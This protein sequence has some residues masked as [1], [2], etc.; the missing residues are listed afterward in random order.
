[1]QRVIN[2]HTRSPHRAQTNQISKTSK[3][4]LP[5][6]GLQVDKFQKE[7]GLVI[8]TGSD[9]WQRAK[10][11]SWIPGMPKVALP[12]GENPNL[13]KWPAKGRNVIIF[14]FGRLETYQQLIELSKCLL[15]HGATW[16]LWCMP[17]HKGIKF[18]RKC[19][20]KAI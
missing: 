9:A 6:Y 5:P 12:F 20:E 19:M 8:C 16:V 11:R 1:M 4:I 14:G 17:E 10:S 7:S 2:N 18:E 13:Y 3:A 15:K